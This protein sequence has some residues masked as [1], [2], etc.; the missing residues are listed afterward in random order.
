[1]MLEDP[2]LL[3]ACETSSAESLFAM[4]LQLHA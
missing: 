4:I 3:K 1:M 2:Q